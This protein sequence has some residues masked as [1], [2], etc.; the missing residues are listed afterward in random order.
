VRVSGL[1]VRPVAKRTNKYGKALFRVVP[2]RRGK[3]LVSAT[4]TG[5]QPIYGSLK[6]R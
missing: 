1:G 5:F 2:R 4:K 6:V 3:L